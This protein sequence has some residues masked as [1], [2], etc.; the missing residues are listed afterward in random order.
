MYKSDKRR[1]TAKR[2]NAG[3]RRRHLGETERNIVAVK[4]GGGREI[5]MLTLNKN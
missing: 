3:V 5:D 2:R 1:N 4:G